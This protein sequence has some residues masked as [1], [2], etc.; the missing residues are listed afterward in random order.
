VLSV[1]CTSCCIH[2]L[3]EI[4]RLSA[5]PVDM[6]VL[7]ENC[8]VCLNPYGRHQVD[9]QYAYRKARIELIH[10]WTGPRLIGVTVH[11]IVWSVN[12]INV[13]NLCRM[14]QSSYLDCDENMI[15]LSNVVTATR[16]ADQ[17]RGY[18]LMDSKV[19]HGCTAHAADCWV[20]SQ[21]CVRFSS[22]NIIQKSVLCS[23]LQ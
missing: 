1:V 18:F 20:S 4:G 7:S 17:T 21:F 2:Y 15:L 5:Q 12:V 3:Y 14:A 13:P 22:D 10:A 8:T 23:D 11:D 6:N 9:I 19:S 16:P